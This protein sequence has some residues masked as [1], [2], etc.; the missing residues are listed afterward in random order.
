MAIT[1]GMIRITL[2][3]KSS[4]LEVRGMLERRAGRIVPMSEVVGLGSIVLAGLLRAEEKLGAEPSPATSGPIL[5]K[6]F[7]L[8]DEAIDTGR[9]VR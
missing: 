9:G 7:Q 5:T 1:S 6:L 3:G 2:D 4:A 8:V